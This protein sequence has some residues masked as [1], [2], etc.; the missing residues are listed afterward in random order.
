[1]V[2]PVADRQVT[3]TVTVE[4]TAVVLVHQTFQLVAAFG[5]SPGLESVNMRLKAD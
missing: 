1:V 5:A 2:P 3:H 4:G